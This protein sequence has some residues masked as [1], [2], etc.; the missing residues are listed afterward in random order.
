VPRFWP[1]NVFALVQ[2]NF[3]S[4]YW[5]GVTAS[6]GNTT[7]LSR[8]GLGEFESFIDDHNGSGEQPMLAT[9]L[10]GY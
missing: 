1:S 2:D 4:N 10:D 5:I 9:Y 3:Y 8:S 6:G 7:C